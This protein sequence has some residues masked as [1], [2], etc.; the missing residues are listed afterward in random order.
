MTNLLPVNI[1]A[2]KKLF[3]IHWYRCAMGLKASPNHTTQAIFLSEEF[4]LGNHQLMINPFQY[5]I[6]CLNLP[7]TVGYKP[8]NVWYSVLYQEGE[9]E[10]ILAIYVDYEI[11]HAA[12]E[13][14]AWD[15][16][17]QVATCKHSIDIQDA[18]W[19]RCPPSQS[20]G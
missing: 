19:K 7:G 14:K 13:K 3:W 10:Y 8:G 1:P 15:A 12:S 20:E 18:A 2:N 9:L 17:H 6:F 5:L 4:L 11:I 16:D